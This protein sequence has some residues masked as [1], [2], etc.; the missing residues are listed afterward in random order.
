[1]N[2]L[3]LEPARDD[4]LRRALAEARVRVALPAN[5]I[6]K[7]ISHEEAAELAEVLRRLPISRSL[8]VETPPS[9]YR[10]LHN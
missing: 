2:A 1:M 10:P 7:R 9:A 5:I 8:D 6:E 4:D 3:L